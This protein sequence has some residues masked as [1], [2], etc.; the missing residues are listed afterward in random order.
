MTDIREYIAADNSEAARRV[1]RRIRD[2][3]RKLARYPHIG[4]PGRVPGTRELV[5][6][7]TPYVVPYIVH[8]DQ[9]AILTVLHGAQEW[10]K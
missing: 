2:A 10:P 3:V 6:P 5:I 1:S 8:R 7:G 4:R 9:L